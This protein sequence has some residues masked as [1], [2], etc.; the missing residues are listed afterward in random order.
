LT[1]GVTARQAD[2]ARLPHIAQGAAAI[3][4]YVLNELPGEVRA[5]T[6]EQLFG[7]AHAAPAC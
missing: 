7:A 1:C 6:E 3:A 5:R 2:A 4:A